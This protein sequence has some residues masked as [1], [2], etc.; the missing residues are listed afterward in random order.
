MN[1]N[2]KRF[3]T[4]P[5]HIPAEYNDKGV[6]IRASKYVF[7]QPQPKTENFFNGME[8][9]RLQQYDGDW[10][11]LALELV[12]YDPSKY[13]RSPIYKWEWARK[14]V[15]LGAEPS[16]FQIVMA[17]EGPILKVKQWG[18]IKSADRNMVKKTL[19][20]YF[21]LVEKLKEKLG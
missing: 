15:K 4:C 1:E 14:S 3:L 20:E 17:W 18:A 21:G 11:E 10:N 5:C 19:M 6:K 2:L 13:G 7:D 8:L 12:L 16:F 9:S